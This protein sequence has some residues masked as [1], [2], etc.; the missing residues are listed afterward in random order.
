MALAA[1]EYAVD[2]A[3]LTDPLVA[4]ALGALRKRD[5][6]GVP[7]LEDLESLRKKLDE[8]FSNMYER[9]G[10]AEENKWHPTFCRMIAAESIFCAC[11]EDSLTASAESV[12]DAI[13]VERNLD[14]PNAAG[15]K[16]L[17]LHVLQS[18]QI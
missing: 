8:D 15:V 13:S 4:Q 10:D 18:E 2:R 1:C 9:Y 6:K 7:S 14:G 16:N 11:H 17:V 5:M 3:R 12:Y